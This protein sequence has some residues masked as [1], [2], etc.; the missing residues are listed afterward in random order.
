MDARTCPGYALINSSSPVLFP[1]FLQGAEG[2]YK[3]TWIMQVEHV[4]VTAK[5]STSSIVSL[6]FS[7]CF[8][9]FIISQDP[10]RP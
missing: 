3:D 5:F 9:Y 6:A 2:K 8:M 1:D 10:Q 4:N 7:I